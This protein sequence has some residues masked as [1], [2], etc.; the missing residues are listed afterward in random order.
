MLKE[1]VTRL[2]SEATKLG[3]MREQYV[4]KLTNT[5]NQ[6]ESFKQEIEALK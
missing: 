2:R 3:K 6:C 4:K 5:Q 1:E